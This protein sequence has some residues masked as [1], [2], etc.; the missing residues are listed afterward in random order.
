MLELSRMVLFIV[1][2]QIGFIATCNSQQV[3]ITKLV[4]LFYTACME[5]EL[6]R[7]K[8]IKQFYEHSF[9]FLRYLI[10]RIKN[11]MVGDITNSFSCQILLIF[12]DKFD[13]SSIT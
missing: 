5:W 7:L 9:I 13:F 1:S 3:K 6:R 4:G 12:I 2:G 11:K 8:N 10:G